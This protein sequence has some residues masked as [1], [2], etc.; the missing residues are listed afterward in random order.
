[1]QRITYANVSREH[2]DPLLNDSR[3]RSGFWIAVFTNNRLPVEPGSIA[4]EVNFQEEQALQC[5]LKVLSNGPENVDVL[6]LASRL[7]SR[8]GGREENLHLKKTRVLKAESLAR[9]AMALD[10]NHVGARF[11]YIVS[12]ALL[13]EMADSPKEKLKNAR[14]IRDQSMRVLAID[15]NHAA[16]HYVMGK[17]HHGLSRLSWFDRLVCEAFLGGLPVA[18]AE[19]ASHYFQRAI[20]LQPDQIL[21]YYGLAGY[22]VDEGRYPEATQVLESALELIELEPDDVVRKRNCRNLLD[23]LKTI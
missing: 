5:Y 3:F 19:E 15:P 23:R 1:M 17:W 9:R 8:T 18:S 22:Y 12:L 14:L 4:L 21:F 11:Q 16:T 10:S 20:D 13:S 7:Y 2:A 6:A